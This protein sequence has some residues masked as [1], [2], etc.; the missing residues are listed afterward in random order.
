MC[1]IAGIIDTTSSNQ[2]FDL[3]RK[4]IDKLGHRGPDYQDTVSDENLAILGHSRLAIIDLAPASNQPMYSSDGRF[5]L[6]FNGEIYNFEELKKELKFYPFKSHSDTEVII[7]S[8]IKWGKECTSKFNGMF[9]FAIWDKQEKELFCSRDRFGIKPFYFYKSFNTF[10]FSS[11]IRALAA[12]P[13]VETA[14]DPLRLPEYLESQTVSA[15]NTILKNIFVLEP[16]T[17]ISLK[18]GQLVKKTYWKPDNFFSQNDDSYDA[19]CKNIK[20]LF[21]ES[22]ERQMIADVSLGAFLSGGIDSSGVVAAMSSVSSKRIKTISVNFDEKKFSEERYSDLISKKF[23]TDHYKIS[24]TAN[25]LL[26]YLPEALESIDHPTGDGINT[27]IVSK[28]TKERGINV[29]LSGLGGDELF[30]GYNVFNRMNTIRRLSWLRK[31]PNSAKGPISSAASMLPSGPHVQ[32]TLDLFNLNNFTFENVYS[33]MRRVI[34]HLEIKSLLDVSNLTQSEHSHKL[35]DGDIFDLKDSKNFLSM[36]SKAEMSSY[37]VNTLLRDSDQMS[38]SSS[39]ELR[40]PFLDHKLVEYV[41]SV[42]DSYKINKKIPKKLFVDSMGELLPN[43]VVNRPKMGFVFPWELWLKTNLRNFAYFHIN[44]LSKREEFNSKKLKGYFEDYLEGKKDISW[45]RIWHLI[46]LDHW[47][48]Q[49][50]L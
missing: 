44:N 46:V 12:C 7:A 15:P 32:K 5:I 16:G 29:A 28:A 27:Y 47:L 37:M 22:V 33:I 1:G 45:S 34:P 41:L 2:N 24:M 20:N 31:I 21:M 48:E 17:S 25:D 10:I 35:I 18:K 40:V 26:D 14:L 38:M 42:K 3:V 19:A 30:A 50:S 11:E 6:V 8:Y 9:A 36:V 13:A 23:N 49:N 43:E 39:L 4:M